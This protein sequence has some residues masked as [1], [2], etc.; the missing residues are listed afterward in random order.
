MANQFSHVIKPDLTVKECAKLMNVSIPTMRAMLRD[1]QLPFYRPR[2][3]LIRIP[4]E[5]IEEMRAG[6]R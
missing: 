1:K 6:Q 4:R 5:A 2:V 3:N